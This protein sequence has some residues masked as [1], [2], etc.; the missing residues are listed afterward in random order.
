M[1]G[2]P[3]VRFAENQ[4]MRTDSEPR[5]VKAASNPEPS[6]VP[7]HSNLRGTSEPWADDPQ[8]PFVELDDTHRKLGVG[9]GTF[10]VIASMVGTGILTTSGFTLAA[11]GQPIALLVIWAIGGVIAL[12]A[13]FCVAELG[14]TLPHAGGDYVFVRRG[15]GPAAGLVC[16]WASYVVGFVGPTAL[17]ASLSSSYLLAPLRGMWPLAAVS[18][19]GLWAI[20]AGLSTIIIVTL[21]VGHL[22]GPRLS[23]TV[24]SVLTILKLALLVAYA[25]AAFTFGKTDWSHLTGGKPFDWAMLPAL[26]S[27]LIYVCYSYTG[28]NAAGYLAGELKRPSRT[29]PRAVVGGVAIVTALYLVLNLAYIVALD[30]LTMGQRPPDDVKNVAALAAIELFGTNVA[31]ALSLAIGASLLASVSAMLLAGSRVVHAMSVDGLL[32]ASL[33]RTEAGRTVSAGAVLAVA[34]PAILLMWT[35]TFHQ[36]LDFTSVGLAAASGLT[37]S[38]VFAVRRRGLARPYSMPLYPLPP[39]IY[40]SLIGWTVAYAVL[41]SDNRWPAIISLTGLIAGFAV[42]WL[43][44]PATVKEI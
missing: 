19:T 29:L 36:L 42:A 4:P 10:L 32:P 34:I 31:T 11:T 20:E 23:G 15:F 28:W 21:T 24:Q 30:P 41:F 27:G 16:G 3:A 7:V 33:G 2:W 14:A 26:A 12:C 43:I 1:V 35:G 38:A 40:L 17:M 44:Q 22:F 5:D 9:T 39:L 25:A 6:P 13:A 8:S 37:I 18:Q